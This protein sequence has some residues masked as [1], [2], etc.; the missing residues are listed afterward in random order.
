[1]RVVATASA[2]RPA[3]TVQR[4]NVLGVGISVLN[5]GTA[6]A[7]IAEALAQGRK[8][9]ICV[10]G[11]HGVIEA[12]SDPAFREVLNRAFLCTPDGMPMVWA[13]KGA[14]FKEMGRVYGP[15]LLA[16]VA[17]W[18]RGS[19][20]THFLYGGAP[21]VAEQMRQRLETSYPGLRVVGTFTPPFGPLSPSDEARL[22]AQ[23]A[24]AQ[25]DLFWV[26]LSTPKQEKFMA[27]YLPRLETKIMVGVGAAFDFYAGRVRQ[28]PRW[29][30][31]SG[32][33]WLFRLCMEPR[34]LW[35]R[36][37]RNNPLFLWLVLC[38]LTRLK[39]FRL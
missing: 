23:V 2:N 11:V 29:L 15:D 31:R 20:H 10:T 22:I 17:E 36:Y 30:Q 14:G 34:R 37:A 13:G 21:G 9:Y 1:M 6:R 7:A 3:M 35:R 38:Q 27:A 12:Q 39:R 16:E 18:T 5:L 25:P 26:G 24:A 19:G 28:A 8:G 4:V 33:E 32:L